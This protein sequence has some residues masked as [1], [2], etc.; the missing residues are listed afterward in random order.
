MGWGFK[1]RSDSESLVC[2]TTIPLTLCLAAMREKGIDLTDVKPRKLTDELASQSNVLITMGCGDEC[3]VVPGV[4]R[5]DWPLD[6][7][8]GEPIERVR[9]RFGTTS[10]VA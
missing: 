2:L 6:D 7:P 9:A 5:D 3:P 4:E 10:R 1:Y 8:K